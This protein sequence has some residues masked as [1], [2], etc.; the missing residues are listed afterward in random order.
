MKN[1]IYLVPLGPCCCY[2]GAQ[3]ESVCCK[4]NHHED[5]YATRDGDMIYEYEL[6]EEHEIVEDFDN[7][8][9]SNLCMH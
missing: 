4:E 2:C 1:R 5:A 3:T 8:P 6:T 7:I 9:A